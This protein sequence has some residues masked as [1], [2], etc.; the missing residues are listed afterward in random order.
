MRGSTLAAGVCL[1]LLGSA[2]GAADQP[3]TFNEKLA[4][5][6]TSL[7]VG[8]REFNGPGADVLARAVSNARYVL[9]GEDHLTRE[10]PAFTADLCRLMAPQGLSALAYPAAITMSA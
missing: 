3:A 8:D 6:R 9:I 4:G 1:A 5:V 10:I 2:A 7:A